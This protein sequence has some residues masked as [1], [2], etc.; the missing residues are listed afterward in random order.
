MSVLVLAASDED[1]AVLYVSLDVY[2]HR[3]FST[4]T[5]QI[6]LRTVNDE[7]L[8]VAYHHVEERKRGT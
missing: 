4:I 6:V 1:T 5:D 3:S 8:S 7:A 2:R